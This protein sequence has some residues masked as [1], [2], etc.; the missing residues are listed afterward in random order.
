MWFIPCGSFQ[1][2]DAVDV[3]AAD[4][5]VVSDTADTAVTR[6]RVAVFLSCAVSGG[7]EFTIVVATLVEDGVALR[8][9]RTR[10]DV[11]VT[12]DAADVVDDDD[13]AGVD[14]G[15][16]VVTGVMGT[17]PSHSGGARS[18]TINCCKAL[19]TCCWSSCTFQKESK[20]GEGRE[21]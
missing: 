14:G 7:D 9:R 17:P 6:R 18:A 5:N 19:S 20:M 15:R 21:R 2:T 10:V 4:F 12:C 8:T 1:S 11:G 13:D 16:I 3:A